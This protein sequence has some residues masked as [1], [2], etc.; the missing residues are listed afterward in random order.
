MRLSEGQGSL[1]QGDAGQW[2]FT[3]QE[4]WT[5]SVSVDYQVSD[6]ELVWENPA[7]GQPGDAIE[8]ADFESD[9]WFFSGRGGVFVS[10]IDGWKSPTGDIELKNNRDNQGQAAS[11]EQF[12]E[13]NDDSKDYYKDAPAIYKELKTA[14]GE[15]YNLTLQYAGRPGYDASVNRFEVF[16]DGVSQGTWS[17]ANTTAPA[18]SSY[19]GSHDWQTLNISFEAASNC[20]RIELCEAGRDVP[21]G[22][23]MR[24]DD[25]R[26]GKLTLDL[27][28]NTA[29]QSF[30]I[31]PTN[32]APT[33]SGPVALG[34]IQEDTS[35]NL[36]SEQLLATASDIDGDRL[37]VE[38]LKVNGLYGSITAIEPGQ[39][40]FTPAKDWNGKLQLDYKISDGNGGRAG[41][42]ANLTVTPVNDAPRLTGLLAKLG[43]GKEDQSFTLYERD[44]LQGFSDV[45]GDELSVVN[46]RIAKGQGRL[47]AGDAGSWI[48]TRLPIGT[49][50]LL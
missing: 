7:S 22:R 5:G 50:P 42:H 31:T 3:P 24:I 19:G 37:S 15:L 17:Q 29:R 47:S 34:A 18:G 9:E 12:I 13:L 36:T 32:D 48:F 2:I 1:R 44:L 27:A 26:I 30:E 4:N 46:L 45:D 23:G 38:D 16:I 28:A 21:S 33:I 49:A 10:T 39:W 35:L 41:V 14:A 40:R 6:G 20:T 43:I 25:L 11:G 8:Q